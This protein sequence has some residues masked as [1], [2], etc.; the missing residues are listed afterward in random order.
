MRF[1]IALSLAL[2][3]V[4]LCAQTW[5][6]PA[7]D[8]VSI[9]RNAAN[10]FTD[11]RLRAYNNPGSTYKD[12]VGLYKFDLS[13]IPDNVVITGMRLTLAMESGFNSPYSSPVV[14]LLHSTDDAWTRGTATAASGAPGAVVCASQS[15]FVHPRHVFTINLSAWTWAN[16]LLD[17][18]LTLVID[19]VNPAYSYVYFYGHTGAPVGP[20][21]QLEVDVTPTCGTLIP[22]GQ[23][24][25]DTRGARMTMT[26][27]GCAGINQTLSVGAALGTGNLA[28]IVLWLGASTTGYGGL[29]LP[30]DLGVIGMPG[31][32][33]YTGMDVYL[34]A[35]PNLNGRGTLPLV[36]P[37]NATLSGATVHFQT[38]AFDPG[39][40]P[41]G[42]LTSNGLT[43][44]L[45]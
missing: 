14:D 11:N 29:N 42:W 4:P 41:L 5:R 3:A 22:F 9:S 26:A 32:R 18:R 21:A 43:V 16:D 10:V 25:L 15:G 24:G 2:L 37:N 35:V 27:S 28:Q 45:R 33:L 40:T 39:A 19:N 30:F 34:G 31:S 36:I 1:P 17:D 8:S 7:V 13:A 38:A 20:N 23:G 6:L 12:V 44:V